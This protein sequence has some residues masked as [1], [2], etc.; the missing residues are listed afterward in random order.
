[1][2]GNVLI[3]RAKERFKFFY[4]KCPLDPV[5]IESGVVRVAGSVL[6]GGEGRRNKEEGCE[7]LLSKHVRFVSILKLI[8]R[9]FGA[10]KERE[11]E[12]KRDD[13]RQKKVEEV[14][15]F[16]IPAIVDCSGHNLI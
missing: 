12:R 13:R 2:C 4:S 5:K 8:S 1:M 7:E 6:L 9:G 3:S 10:G 15:L 11:K 14:S 16:S